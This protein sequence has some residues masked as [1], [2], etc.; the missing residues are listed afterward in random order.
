MDP[1]SGMV[2]TIEKPKAKSV[3][4]PATNTTKPTNNTPKDT[5]KTTEKKEEKRV[6]EKRSSSDLST[7]LAAVMAEKKKKGS[8]SPKSNT[9]TKVETIPTETAKEEAKKEDN[10]SLDIEK[11]A[12]TTVKDEPES[13][14]EKKDEGETPPG[15]STDSGTENDSTNVD[16]GNGLS[17]TSP[18]PLPSSNVTSNDEK[19]R[20]LEQRE[21]QLLQAMENIAKLHDQIQQIQEEAEKSKSDFQ[22]KIETLEKEADNPSSSTNLNKNVKK[23]ESTVEDLQKQL[24]SRD[25]KIQGLMAEGEKLSKVELKHSTTIKKLRAEKIEGDKTIADLTKKLEKATADLSRASEK[26]TKQGE[27][28]KKLQESVKLLSDLTEQQTKH[29]NKLESEKLA[30]NKKHA[31]TE[32]SL[33]KALESID[34]ERTK[35][36]LEAEQVNAAAL[37]KE[38]KANDRLHKELTKLTEKSN[39]MEAKLRKEIRELQITLQ[40]NEEQ[41]G[42]REDNLRKEVSDLQLKLQQSDSKMDDLS[43]T[44]DDATTPLLRQIEHLQTQHALAIKHRDQTE[45]S[46]ILRMQSVE[47]ERKKAIEKESKLEQTIQSLSKRIEELEQELNSSQAEIKELNEEILSCCAT[48]KELVEKVEKLT[49]EKEELIEKEIRDQEGLKSQYQRLMKEKLYEEKKQFEIRLSKAEKT[50]QQQQQQYQQQQQQQNQQQQSASL[51]ANSPPSV[52]SRSSFDSSSTTPVSSTILVERLQ[53][54]IRQ[55]ENQLSFY[56]TQLQSSSQSR[57]ELS[58]EVLGMSQEI[59]TL[60]KSLKNLNDKDQQYQQLNGRY[61]TLLELLGERT[62]EVEE[63]KADLSDVKEM[64]KSQIIELV[65]KVD[66]LSNSKK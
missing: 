32:A 62:E 56:Q 36:K 64:Y 53:A 58:E 14:Q 28:E 51:P 30:S 49:K 44:M 18:P 10:K 12:D 50:N 4:S 5:S 54:N 29:I 1:I 60:R 42:L 2:T 17:P 31:E 45:Q 41:S 8:D 57:D 39:N 43:T 40:T 9:T 65:Q 23:L 37:E 33:K 27:S 46:M 66:Q 13:T 22:A 55:L 15:T 47:A 7:R 34:E 24:A 61:Q 11:E 6:S 38:I 20:I 52:S 19:D 35:A 21:T 16:P 48:N 25:E 26:G 3:N 63:L 59:E